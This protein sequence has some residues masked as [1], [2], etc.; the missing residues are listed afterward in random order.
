[1]RENSPSGVQIKRGQPRLLG[2][3]HRFIP[4]KALLYFVSGPNLTEDLYA[5]QAIRSLSSA[6]EAQV[7]CSGV[8]AG[9]D[10]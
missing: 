10:G 5:L 1:M 2:Y 3:P 9:S 7:I 6:L 8:I 4:D